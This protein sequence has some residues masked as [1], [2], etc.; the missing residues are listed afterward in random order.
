MNADVNSALQEVCNVT[1]ARLLHPLPPPPP[2]LPPRPAAAPAAAPA[3]GAHRGGGGCA[4]TKG[5]RAPPAMT[6]SGVWRGLVGLGAAA[7]PGE[8]RA[9]CGGPQRAHAARRPLWPPPPGRLRRG[10][11]PPSS[12]TR[13]A[14]AMGSSGEGCAPS[15]S[16]VASPSA[17]AHRHPP[18]R[19][20]SA[21]QGAAAAGDASGSAASAP[22]RK[23]SSGSRRWRPR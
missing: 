18:H 16:R 1:R 3:P 7:H 14:T 20:G 8:Q 9:R 13:N 11:P 23:R 21:A 15:S 5:T 10:G 6:R 22:D 2:L 4:G 17:L 19:A 12:L